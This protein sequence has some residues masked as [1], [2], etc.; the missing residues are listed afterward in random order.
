MPATKTLPPQV[1]QDLASEGFGVVRPQDT[2]VILVPFTLP[3]EVVEIAILRRKR[4][5][6]Y[7]EA[8]A[9]HQTSPNR[10]E[11]RCGDFGRCGGCRWQMMDY[12]YQLQYKRR[13][14]QQAF[15]HLAHLPVEVPSVVPSPVIWHYRNK[16]EY[17]FGENTQGQLLLGFHPRG[18]FARVLDLTA[19]QLVPPV[20]EAVRRTVLAQARLKGLRAY[21]PLRHKGLLR[22]L[23]VR[24]T[25]DRLVAFLS[26]A[27]DCPE[28]AF[29]LLGPVKESLPSLIGFGYFHNPKR[30]DSLA[31]LEP[32][33]LAGET[34]L[35]FQVDGRRYKLGIQDFFQVNLP[36]AENLLRWIRER[37]PD[38][39]PALYDLYGGVGFFGIGLADRAE[40]VILVEKLPQAVISAEEN[41]RHNR[42]RFPT[43]AWQTYAGALEDLTQVALAPPPGSVAIV[44]P[45]R[46][47]LHPTVRKALRTLPFEEIF[48]V[49]CHP[50]T[51]ARDLAELQEA[52][53]ILAVQPFD[54]FPHTTGIENIV[55][56][57][58]RK[59]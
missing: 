14:V 28:I 55:W 24:G 57:K 8:V 11:P 18:D 6:W 42:H 47:G 23:V 1:V 21:N 36:Q 2:P 3:G 56:I 9:W 27:D 40:K 44:D 33:P 43:T 35:E 51:Q 19:C 39:C 34:C 15:L 31:D 52:Y 7:G 46:E 26:L 59:K 49:S 25:A 10:V 13:F 50:A 12:P 38:R 30:N 37:M 41:F 32:I 53:Q 20:F 58:R 48:Y 29:D 16:A 5:L 4:Q 45:P 17:T 22:Q 54:L